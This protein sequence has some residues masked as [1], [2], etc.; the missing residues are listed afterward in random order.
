MPA[1]Q[2]Q[3]D[4]V[5]TGTEWGLVIDAAARGGLWGAAVGL[6][7]V[8]VWWLLSQLGR[9]CPRDG[10]RLY[11]QDVKARLLRSAGYRCEH[12]YAFVLRCWRTTRL[13]ADHVWPWC[14]GGRTSYVNGSILCKSHNARKGG[15]PPSPVYVW[16]MRRARR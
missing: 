13:E 5:V 10:Q 3:R 16:M 12:R 9:V 11:P 6:V 14:L 15:R 1:S 7:A 4:A 2:G 8:S